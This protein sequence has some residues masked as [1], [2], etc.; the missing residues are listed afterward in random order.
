MDGLPECDDLDVGLRW[1][2]S[3]QWDMAYI[4]GETCTTSDTPSPDLATCPEFEPATEFT[5]FFDS[6]WTIDDEDDGSIQPDESTSQS[7]DT[8]LDEPD[9]SE[10]DLEDSDDPDATP[11]SSGN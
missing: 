1:A 11:A 4:P 7:E 9:T 3:D 10:T 2:S 5:T 8:P 6:D